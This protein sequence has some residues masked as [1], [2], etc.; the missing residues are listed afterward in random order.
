MVRAGL[1]YDLATMWYCL[2]WTFEVLEAVYYYLIVLLLFVFRMHSVVLLFWC[3]ETMSQNPKQL[4]LL[5]EEI[6]ILE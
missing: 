1:Q 2:S 4:F 6:T 3:F 5:R